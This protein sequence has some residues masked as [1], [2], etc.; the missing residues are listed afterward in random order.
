MMKKIIVLLLFTGM[1]FQAFSDGKMFWR[2]KVPPAI[3]YQR[4]LIV[5]KD[6]R[7]TLILQSKYEVQ[8]QTP[9][10][11]QMP[12]GWVVPVPAVPEL[13][14]MN[15][16]SAHDFFRYLS[17]ISR[18]KI[19]HASDIVFLTACIGFA[20]SLIL[21]VLICILKLSGR[22]C[23]WAE[24][25]K[26]VFNFALFCLICAFFLMLSLPALSSAGEGVDVLGQYSVGIYDVKIIKAQNSS[27]I[28][29]W[30]KENKF[31]FGDADK[32]AFD[33]YISRGWCF[34]VANINQERK[35]KTEHKVD[36]EGLA[37]PLILRFPAENPIYPLVLTGTGGHDTMILIYLIA[38]SKMICDNRMKLCYA[39]RVKTDGLT[40][41][42][43]PENSMTQEE[44]S[45]TYLCKFKG[46]LTPADMK[47]D[48]VFIPAKNDDPFR[49]HKVR[50]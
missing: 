34:V 14:T 27:A 24:T 50:W 36:R 29:D 37:A 4:A 10:S 46:T 47:S 3:P 22:P 21:L 1:I 48:M 16:D 18:P 30:L 2:E 17:M 19:T 42:I 28:I 6:G 12:L 38:E 43:K 5:F 11:A 20:A 33:S 31:E 41:Y 32:T 25:W 9:Q 26:E 23:K 35:G 40:K 7:E 49:E 8:R 44:L 39:G 13:A 15:A 45:L